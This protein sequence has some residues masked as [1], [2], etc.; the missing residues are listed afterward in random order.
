MT[1]QRTV[2]GRMTHVERHL[3]LAYRLDNFDMLL[4]LRNVIG[5]SAPRSDPLSRNETGW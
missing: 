1:D 4:Q 3:S 5:A 2:S